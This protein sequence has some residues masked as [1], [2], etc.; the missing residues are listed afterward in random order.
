MIP[1]WISTFLTKRRQRI[2]LRAFETKWGYGLQGSRHLT[3]GNAGLVSE[4]GYLI[5]YITESLPS[6]AIDDFDDYKCIANNFSYIDARIVVELQS[7]SPRETRLTSLETA[8]GNLRNLRLIVKCLTAYVEMA[9]AVG[10]P[11]NPMKQS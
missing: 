7:D 3:I 4:Y 11:L 5:R 1:T 8:R 2:A 6:G 10:L 9:H